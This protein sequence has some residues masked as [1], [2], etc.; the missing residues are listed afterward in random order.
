M[1]A[2]AAQFAVALIIGASAGFARGKAHSTSADGDVGLV[3]FETDEDNSVSEGHGV[4]R[5]DMMYDDF[6]IV[7]PCL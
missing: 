3:D 1:P 2:L 7:G 6:I 4:K 5:Y